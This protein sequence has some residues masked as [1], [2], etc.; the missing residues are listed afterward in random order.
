MAAVSRPVSG[1]AAGAVFATNLALP[2]RRQGK[3][4]DVYELPGGAG[5]GDREA[6]LLI[7]ATDRISA[8]DCVM[9][10]GIPDK[11]KILT[12]LEPS[13]S[14]SSRRQFENSLLATD[15]ARDPRAALRPTRPACAGGRC[16]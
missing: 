7:V 5:P 11:G 4:R 16:S 15:V 6:R 12:A 1:K 8:F 10:N 3:V 9:P 13:G 2:G 14:D